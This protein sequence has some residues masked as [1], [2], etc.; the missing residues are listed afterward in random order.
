[1]M[2]R[3]KRSSRVSLS[4]PRTKRPTSQ[5]DQIEMDDCFD[6]SD[7]KGSWKFMKEFDESFACGICFVSHLGI[8]STLSASSTLQLLNS[9]RS[10]NFESYYLSISLIYPILPLR[11]GILTAPVSIKSCSH[12]F[13]SACIRG[14]L[15]SGLDINKKKCP[16]CSSNASDG[17]LIPQH[18]LALAADCWR[19]TK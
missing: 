4:T 2:K 10:S 12:T 19:K 9:L 6:A 3:S 17:S 8:H 15:N 18:G 1:M 16:K 13:C 5:M 14:H 7:W 11:Q